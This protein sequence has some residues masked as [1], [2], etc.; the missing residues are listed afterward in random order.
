MVVMDAPVT[1]GYRKNKQMPHVNGGAFP[2]AMGTI[3]NKKRISK[4][5]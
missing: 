1:I 4:W 2:I 3:I 5:E